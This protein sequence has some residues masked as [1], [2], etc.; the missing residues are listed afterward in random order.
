M[1]IKYYIGIADFFCEKITQHGAKLLLND[2]CT[3]VI[4][5]QNLH[6]KITKKIIVDKNYLH[7][8]CEMLPQKTDEKFNICNNPGYP[9]MG[10]NVRPI[11]IENNNGRQI[12]FMI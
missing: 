1:I 5:E 3:R 8:Y 12:N 6:L 4:L 11:Y 10:K 9:V 2:I 7:I